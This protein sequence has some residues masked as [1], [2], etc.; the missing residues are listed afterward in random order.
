MQ[1]ISELSRREWLGLCTGMGSVAIAG[2]Q[3]STESGDFQ[4]IEPPSVSPMFRNDVMNIGHQDPATE[5][6][7]PIEQQWDFRAS[8]IQSAPSLAENVVIITTLG[9]EVVA[10]GRETGE[11][12]WRYEDGRRMY[13]TPTVVNER[14]FIGSRSSRIYALEIADGS[15]TWEFETEEPVE[16]TVVINDESV[17]ALDTGATLYALDREDGDERWRT[18]IGERIRDRIPGPSPAVVGDKVLAFDGG[19]QLVAVSVSD[20]SERWHYDLGLSSHSSILIHDMTALITGR[21]VTH[22]I[23][24]EE[25]Q[26]R[27]QT[28]TMNGEIFGGPRGLIGEPAVSAGTAYVGST[29]FVNAFDL[30]DG[31]PIWS[32]RTFGNVYAPPVVVG[33]TIYAGCDDGYL[34]AFDAADGTEYWNH[35]FGRDAEIIGPPA[36]D[37]KQL[38][39]GLDG[40]AGEGKLIALLPK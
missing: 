33:E 20:G 15:V 29:G 37:N 35:D 11:T 12:R 32:A 3:E 28:E 21:S 31:H 10:I 6:K 17:F 38:Y 18:K 14:V 36:V 9:R 7:E 23:G 13:A 30:T 16:S 4:E 1:N 39:V 19:R 2:C 5:I 27:W 25:G 24:V 40:E 22:A 26:E 8:G 34:Y